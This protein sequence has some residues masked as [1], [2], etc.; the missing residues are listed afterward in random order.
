VRRKPP[1]PMRLVPGAAAFGVQA[2]RGA[3]IAPAINA[4]AADSWLAF[5]PRTATFEQHESSRGEMGADKRRPTVPTVTIAAQPTVS[6]SED[7]RM[8]LEQVGRFAH[9]RF[10]SLQ[11]RMDR[12]EWWPEDAF[13][14]LGANGYL[15]VTAPAELGGAGLD[16]FASGLI[17]QAIARWNPAVALGVLAHENLCLNNILANADA[18]LAKR[19]IPGMCQ[20]TVVGA[21]GLTEPGAGSDALGGMRTTA[22]RKGGEYVL[23]G[24][25]MFITN[26]PIADVI[27]VYAKTDRERGAKGISAF[28]VETDTP[29]FA[30]AQKLEKM[31]FRG[32]Q[33]AEILF[34][35][36][37]VPAENMVG[38]ENHGVAVVM[39]GLD[40]ERIS[41][42]FMIIGI[43]ERALELTIDYA[44]SRRQFGQAI[45]EFQLVQG[46]IADMYTELE[47]LRSFTYQVGAEVN[48]LEPRSPRTAA[49][50]RAA[51]VVL[52]AGLTV[53]QIVDSA[54]QVHGGNGYIWETEVNRLYRAG[55][56][57]QIGAGTNEIRRLIVAR[58]LLGV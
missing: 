42:S 36:C 40:L 3:Q 9:D 48:E 51:A 45:A 22:V 18:D 54:V 1:L 14:A 25:K 34:D 26:G 28:V 2:P 15:G 8:I 33:T 56:L 17:L 21:L 23:N 12:D 24:T 52:K 20:G 44:R 10:F 46:L 55:K 5:Q 27:L 13:P 38:E 39:N 43:A 29:G 41:L 57:L 19:V 31:G 30:V 7:H 11:E 50:K 49:H 35:D 6:V 53:M 4:D 32:S 16:F 58:E 47:A 37:R